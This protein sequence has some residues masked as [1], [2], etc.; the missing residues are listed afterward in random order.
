MSMNAISWFRC[1]AANMIPFVVQVPVGGAL[2]TARAKQDGLVRRWQALAVIL[3]YERE[4]KR[5]WLTVRCGA[6]VHAVTSAY[7]GRASISPG[8]DLLITLL[9]WGEAGNCGNVTRK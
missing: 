1:A 5:V 3:R 8:L 4:P 6:Q 9:H 2:V 7:P